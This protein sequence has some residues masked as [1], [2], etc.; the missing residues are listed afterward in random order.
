MNLNKNID[1]KTTLGVD[2]SLVWYSVS[3]LYRRVPSGWFFKSKYM[4]LK[5]MITFIYSYYNPPDG[6]A[7]E[8]EYPVVLFVY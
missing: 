1:L 4:K 8:N 3:V 5:Y 6:H 7:V 2:A